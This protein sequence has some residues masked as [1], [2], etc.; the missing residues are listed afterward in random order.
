MSTS[1][2]T[3][4]TQPSASTSTRPADPPSPGAP[5]DEDEDEILREALARVERAAQGARDRAVRAR[6]QED[7]L[8]ERRRKLA[9][10]ATARSQGGNSTGDVSAS[11]RRPI[12]EVS[13]LK[14]KGKGKAKVQP[15]GEDPDDG[16]DGNDDDDDEEDREPCER[17]RS[18]KIPCLQQA[19]KWSSV[20][21]KPC[22]DSK[23][24]CSYSGRPYVVK[25]E[26]GPSPSGERLAV[27][28]S[29]MAQILADNRALRE[30][31]S[32]TQQYLRQL[33]RR[34]EDDHTRLISMDTRMSLMGMG[35]GP[36]TAG[37]S[38]RIAERRRPLKRRRI[39]EESDEEREEEGEEMEEREK[40]TEKDGEGEEEGMA[41]AEARADKGKGKEVVE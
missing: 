11:P 33:L 14:S 6:E 7:E 10:A 23:V 9:E 26:G 38:R 3:T 28:E 13:R 19:G 24:R 2:T 1:C 5:I 36:V 34:Q 21:C 29:Q 4:I 35:E 27:L 41:P 25:K 22:H 40:E 8:V 31:N 15:V 37:P 18:K 39:I 12:V 16:D 30:A 20:I 17:C 32:K